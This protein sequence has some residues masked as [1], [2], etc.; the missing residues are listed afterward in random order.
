[1]RMPIKTLATVMLAA[2]FS[3][4]AAAQDNSSEFCSSRTTEAYHSPKCDW[5]V[6][7]DPQRVDD[8]KIPH[9]PAYHTY[10]RWVVDGQTYILAY[11]DVDQ[12]PQEMMVDVYLE[13]SSGG[14][15]LVGSIRIAGVVNGVSIEKLTGSLIPDIVFRVESGQLQYVDVLRFA[16]GKAKEVFWYGASELEIT[17]Q[18]KAMIVAR[19]KLS[20]VVEEF[21]WD[22]RTNRFAKIRE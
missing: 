22:P 21:A 6:V 14:Y 1:M 4:F 16:E 12:Q 13:G 10:S 15:K 8:V 17:T 9:R 20:N 5:F 19:S 2:L 11:R 7:H 18:P 3:I